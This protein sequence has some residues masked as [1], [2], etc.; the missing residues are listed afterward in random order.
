M[1][2]RIFTGII[3]LLSGVLTIAISG[4]ED[5]TKGSKAAFAFTKDNL[6]RLH[7]VANSDEVCDQE[8][9]LLVRDRVLEETSKIVSARSREEALKLLKEKRSYLVWAAEDELRRNNLPYNA[10]VYVGR[11]DFPLKEYIFGTL[12]AGDYDALRVV[13]GDGKGRNWWC[14]LFPPVCHLE[15]PESAKEEGKEEGEA[16]ARE[17]KPEQLKL[18]WKALEQVAEKKDLVLGGAWEDWVRLFQMA[19]IS[20]SEGQL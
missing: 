15:R 16:E 20:G 12:P 2:N 14:I 9:K 1:K 5:K 18:R 19:T 6:I 3:I 13:L 7:V 11:F 8:V 10:T 17:I 4:S